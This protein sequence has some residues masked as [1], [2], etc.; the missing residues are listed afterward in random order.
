MPV[1]LRH[2]RHI[3]RRSRSGASQ[4]QETKQPRAEQPGTQQPGAK[5]PVPPHCNQVQRH[6]RG[7]TPG[8]STSPASMRTCLLDDNR[9][10]QLRHGAQRNPY[11]RDRLE[12]STPL[13]R[14]TTALTLCPSPAPP[15]PPRAPTR[16]RLAR[17]NPCS[18]YA[19][20]IK[21]IG[22]KRCFATPIKD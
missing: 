18:R 21:R 16:G 6:G 10:P 1:L 14:A 4:L 13:R 9:S 19:S 11:G 8:D 2:S 22:Y 5:Q 12:A 7:C 20:A 3:T 15:P 17:R